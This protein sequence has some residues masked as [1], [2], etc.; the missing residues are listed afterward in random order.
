MQQSALYRKNN[1]HE[2]DITEYICN[3]IVGIIA[4]GAMLYEYLYI[5][6]VLMVGVI[7]EKSPGIS[8]KVISAEN[9]P[10]SEPEPT[11]I[12]FE[13]FVYLPVHKR[14]Y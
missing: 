6:R 12:Y 9:Y 2:I 4:V 14:R 5:S 7:S 8:M 3:K 11:L 10:A 13:I 1:T